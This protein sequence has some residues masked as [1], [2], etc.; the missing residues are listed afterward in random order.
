MVELVHRIIFDEK[1]QAAKAFLFG[2]AFA[3]RSSDQ[4]GRALPDVTENLFVRQRAS[5]HF[6]ERRVHRKGQVE[7][8]INQRAVQ[9]EDQRAHIG[10]I[11]DFFPH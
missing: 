11:G 2:G 10:K 1:F 9:I 4:A 5:A 6:P 8:G 7:F 3:Q